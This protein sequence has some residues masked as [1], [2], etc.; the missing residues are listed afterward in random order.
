MTLAA[1]SG[2]GIWFV[3]A[4]A[5]FLLYVIG[6]WKVFAKAGQHGWT[7]IIPILNILVMLRIVKRPLWWIILALIPFV[8]FVILIIVLLDLAKAFGHGV[9]YMLG[10]YFLPFIFWIMLGFGESEYQLEPEPLF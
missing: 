10:L 2:A 3:V 7:C 4:L 6:A 9:M 8:N 5:I 1:N